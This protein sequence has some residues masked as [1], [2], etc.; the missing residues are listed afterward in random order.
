MVLALT[1][2]F[3]LYTKFPMLVDLHT[4]L[5]CFFSNHFYFKFCL[6]FLI[7]FFF[8]YIVLKV[9]SY[10]FNPDHAKDQ[11]NNVL[12]VFL[13]FRIGLWFTHDLDLHVFQDSFKL[14]GVF[15]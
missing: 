13:L 3:I 12:V 1:T 10:L 9:L 8:F 14:F 6:S 4:R 2:Y 5:D 7:L 11:E 15:G